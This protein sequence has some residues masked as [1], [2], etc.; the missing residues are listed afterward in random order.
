[1][2]GYSRKGADGARPQKGSTFG[3]GSDVLDRR[4]IWSLGLFALCIYAL[5][6]GGHFY[7]WDDLQKFQALDAWMTRGEFTI[8][9]GWV[10][11]LRGGRY[12]WF[13]LGGSLLMLPGYMI[14]HALAPYVGNALP[15]TEVARVIIS[16]QNTV[17]SALFVMAI[18]S[19]TR[20]LG[21]ARLGCTISALAFGFATFAWPYA[22]SSWSEPAAVLA[23]FVGLAYAFR[24]GE[25]RDGAPFDL[26]AAG[27]GLGTATL[28]RQELAIPTVLSF[29]WLLW[30]NRASGAGLVGV[31]VWMGVPLAGFAIATIWYEY[32]RFG[33]FF[34][35]PNF[36]LP[37]QRVSLWERP[38]FA[39]VNVYRYLISP[40]HGIIWF[41]PA[42]VAGLLGARAFLARFPRVGLFGALTVLPLFLF[43]VVGWGPSSWA[44]GLR[45]NYMVLPF[46]MLPLAMVDWRGWRGFAAGAAIVAGVAIQLIAIPYDA[47]YLYERDIART[48]GATIRTIMDQPAHAPIGLALHDLPVMLA[49][50][51][52]AWSDPPAGKPPAE[53]LRAARWA[54]VG[55]TWWLL[56]RVVGLPR[57]ALTT[58]ALTLVALALA[59]AGSLIGALRTRVG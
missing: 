39:V 52:G 2:P 58:G 3:M 33:T 28:I 44:W 47:N 26:L 18:Y 6:A 21:L 45:Y 34:K 20:Q 54:G 13:P 25:R 55:D 41:S 11:G 51:V 38:G 35:P 23:L 30:R 37:T 57:W 14:G 1:M 43:Y 53:A 36:T 10:E 8:E 16:F 7:S 9:K 50:T 19:V 17:I 27:M 49:A 31:F 32:V 15:P 56:Y 59:A 29:G 22:K 24:A 48:P 5:S 42:V 4:I 12:S 40:N 46:L